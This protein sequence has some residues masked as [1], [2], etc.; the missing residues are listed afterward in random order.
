[1]ALL[2]LAGTIKKQRLFEYT[3]T[4]TLAILVMNK[5]P[6]MFFKIILL[7]I[8]IQNN[9]IIAILMCIL[10]LVLCLMAEFILSKILPWT[11]G[12]KKSNR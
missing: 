1:M 11:F 9:Y 5:F 4:K 7:K 6:I 2:I 8:G 3:G 10:T 12:I